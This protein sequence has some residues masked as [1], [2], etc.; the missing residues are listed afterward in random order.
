M[1][2][3]K[4]EEPS[5]L[6]EVLRRELRAI[7]DE[8]LTPK[9]CNQLCRMATAAKDALRAVSNT[10]PARKG[11]SQGVMIGGSPEA[12]EYEDDDPPLGGVS[13]DSIQLPNQETMGV[14]VVQELVGMFK[15]LDRTRIDQLVD[16]YDSAKNA[17]LDEVADKLKKKIEAKVGIEPSAAPVLDAAP[18]MAS[19]APEAIAS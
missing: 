11:R 10:P 17:G 6:A 13:I 15:G 14:S 8:P 2:D 5:S 12:Y 4:T 1:T 18:A 7:L 16:A 3:D 19:L 9:A